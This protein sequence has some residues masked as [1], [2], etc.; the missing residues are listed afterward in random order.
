MHLVTAQP[1][2]D[3]PT[4]RVAALELE[5][6][7]LAAIELEASLL[8]GLLLIAACRDAIDILS[9]PD[10]DSQDRARVVR[11]LRRALAQAEVW[12]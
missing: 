6:S 4:R 1:D 12:S 3:P 5:A 10:E 8:S 2:T 9:A 11:L 7:R